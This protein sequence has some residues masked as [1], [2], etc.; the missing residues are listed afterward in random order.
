MTPKDSRPDPCSVDFGRE[1]LK[2]WCEFCRGFLGGFFPPVFFQGKTPEKIHQ[3]L[4][5]I[6]PGLGSEKFPSDFCR[7][8]F[9][10]KTPF[11]RGLSGTNSGGRFAPG[12][13]CSLPRKALCKEPDSPYYGS[14]SPGNCSGSSFWSNQ[15][16]SLVARISF[17]DLVEL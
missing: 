7:S 9:L 5:K 2:F 17:R 3:I 8:L 10:T 6:H 13:F 12:R 4:R 16:L 15:L 14:G 1:A 11:G